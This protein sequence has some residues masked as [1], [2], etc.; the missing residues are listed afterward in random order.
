M[1]YVLCSWVNGGYRGRLIALKEVD[2]D[3]SEL[4]EA[5]VVSG[6]TLSFIDL[7]RPSRPTHLLDVQRQH[8]PCICPVCPD[9]LRASLSGH[10][11]G[12]ELVRKLARRATDPFQDALHQQ[13]LFTD[14]VRTLGE[15]SLK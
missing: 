9:A 2:P 10:I 12:T 14:P 8:H 13:K 11:E 1:L 7:G 3:R 6:L 4:R 15:D 5:S